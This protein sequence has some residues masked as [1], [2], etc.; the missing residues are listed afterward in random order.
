VSIFFP[1][2][3]SS[4]P[5]P[6]PLLHF[7]SERAFAGIPAAFFGNAGENMPETPFIE[8]YQHLLRFPSLFCVK[9]GRIYVSFVRMSFGMYPPIAKMQYNF[10]RRKF[11]MKKNKNNSCRLCSDVLEKVQHKISVLA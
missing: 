8:H 1:Q 5:L 9:T 10:F 11:A 3:I 2:T 7:R 4:A 6:Y